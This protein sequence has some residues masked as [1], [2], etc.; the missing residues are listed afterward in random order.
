MGVRRA[1][2]LEDR[3]GNKILLVGLLF[4]FLVINVASIR[5]KSFTTDEENHYQY[6]ENILNL[7]SDRFDDSKMPFSALNALPA[8]LSPIVPDGTLQRYLIKEQTGRLVTIFFSV[9]IAYLIF[10]WSRSL[11]GFFPGLLSV[12]LYIFDPNIIAHSRLMT[13]DIYAAGMGALT[14]FAFWVYSK[15]R[16][17]KNAMIF[18]LVLGLSQLAKYTSV[19]LFPILIVIATLRDINQWRR[20]YQMRNFR[21]AT[22]RLYQGG[23]TFIIVVVMCILIINI[24]FLFNKTFSQL[25]D[26]TFRSELFQTLQDKL[27][28]I[29]FLPIPT[30]YPFLDGLDWVQARERSGVGYARLYMM[31][32]LRRADNFNGYFIFASFV[33]IPISTQ[34]LVFMAIILYFLNWEK[35][36]FFE[37]DIFL[38]VPIL[39]Y[40][41]YFNFIFRA[42]IGIRFYLVLFPFLYVFTG[43]VVKKWYEFSSTIKSGIGILLIYLIGS[44]IIAYPHN[45]PYFN[46]IVLDQRNAYKYLVDS[47]L[48]WEQAEWYLDQYLNANPDAKYNPGRPTLGTIVVSP[49]DLVGIEGDQNRLTWLRKYFVPNDIIA[50]VYLVYEIDEEGYQKML[51]L[52]SQ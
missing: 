4:V 34:I 32:E 43:R 1:F 41:I 31:G 12:S 8:K 20:I 49:N 21:A 33:K 24:G 52:I 45:I 27:S 39:F 16:T 38:F 17:L 42:Q 15:N 37:N 30:P 2:F 51:D 10:R 7:K 11:F 28:P 26:Y 3:I 6:G 22:M 50:D 44:V 5:N 13:T 46:E 35:G 40:F 23:K 47:N 48:D 14:I 19:Y 9:G 25:K 18:A 36:E 29:G